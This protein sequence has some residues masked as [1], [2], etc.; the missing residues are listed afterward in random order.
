MWPELC[1]ESGPSFWLGL[2]KYLKIPYLGPTLSLGAR[3]TFWPTVWPQSGQILIQLF[4]SF[5]F[6]IFEYRPK[7]WPHSG[8]EPRPATVALERGLGPQF[9][10]PFWRPVGKVFGEV[11][12]C[13]W[14]AC[15]V[16]FREAF[17]ARFESHSTISK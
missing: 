13:A 4:G 2:A 6:I 15:S 14:G 3:A 16:M 10:G 9:M 1:P 7:P 17:K 8:H 11:M 5:Y 12:R